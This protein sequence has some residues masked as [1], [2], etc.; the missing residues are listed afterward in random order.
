VLWSRSRPGAA[1]PAQKKRMSR[2]GWAASTG[3]SI[4]CRVMDDS[5][6]VAGVRG[7]P[8]LAPPPPASEEKLWRRLPL[9]EDRDREG[10]IV[11]R[12]SLF[13][14]RTCGQRIPVRHCGVT[15]DSPTGCPRLAT[16]GLARRTT[17]TWRGWLGDLCQI[18]CPLAGLFARLRRRAASHRARLCSRRRSLKANETRA[19]FGTGSSGNR[20]RVPP[21]VVGRGRE[22]GIGQA[23]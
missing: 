12:R 8:A 7:R 21:A 19:Q 13:R 11:C 14:G 4:A 10:E 17:A 18:S 5:G 20:L 15:R 6:Q 9:V 3:Y 2:K 1:P 23:R 16:S 22:D